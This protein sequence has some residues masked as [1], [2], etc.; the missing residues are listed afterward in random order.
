M[1][2]EP[3]PVRDV[4]GRADPRERAEV[5]DEVS[6]VEVPAV[7]CHAGPFHL[8]HSVDSPHCP[9]ET[10]EAAEHLGREP[11]LIAEHLIDQSDML[12]TI[13][14]KDEPFTLPAGRGERIR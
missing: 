2:H 10:L 9:V 6:L 12:R 3:R 13:S 7:G 11:H 4:I 14:G 5:V 1:I 8:A